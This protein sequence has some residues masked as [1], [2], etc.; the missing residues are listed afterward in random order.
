MNNIQNTD[1]HPRPV[2]RVAN[3]H[4]PRLPSARAVPVLRVANA[5][6]IEASH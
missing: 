3:A 6:P 5:H 2:L 1:H 4:R